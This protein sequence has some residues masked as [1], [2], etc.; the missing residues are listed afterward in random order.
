MAVVIDALL[1]YLTDGFVKSLVYTL[2][3]FHSFSGLFFLIILFS[4]SL[5]QKINLSIFVHRNPI[6]LI[7][8][9]ALVYIT[10]RCC[11]HL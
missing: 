3:N 10:D 6:F 9:T 4:I 5:Y 2:E 8:L 1:L 11:L 7:G